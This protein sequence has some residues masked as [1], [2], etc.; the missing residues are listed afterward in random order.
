MTT[1]MALTLTLAGICLVSLQ[2]TGKKMEQPDV[3]IGICK[4]T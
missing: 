4:V 2:A 3:Y 1:V